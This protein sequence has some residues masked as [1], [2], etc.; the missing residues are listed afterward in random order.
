MW[1]HQPECN[2]K[3]QIP[4]KAQSARAAGYAPDTVRHHCD[5]QQSCDPLW[6]TVMW[7]PCRR[8]R[9]CS[10]PGSCSTADAVAA[11]AWQCLAFSELG[12]RDVC[13]HGLCGATAVFSGRTMAVCPFRVPL[14]RQRVGQCAY[15]HLGAVTLATL[16]RALGHVGVHTV[17]SVTTT[18]AYAPVYVAHP[19]SRRYA[20]T[21]PTGATCAWATHHSSRCLQGSSPGSTQSSKL[22]RY[23]IPRLNYTFR[24]ARCMEISSPASFLTPMTHECVSSRW[25]TCAGQLLIQ[26]T[27]SSLRHSLPTLKPTGSSARAAT[28]Q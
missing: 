26:R 22:H 12:L 10:S 27:P 28:P 21:T 14:L 4:P 17:P 8:A 24:H 3:C 13:Y 15:R 7:E 16:T 18:G 6:G 25:C 9:A 19:L 2:I 1:P 5:T 20:A 23:S 11:S